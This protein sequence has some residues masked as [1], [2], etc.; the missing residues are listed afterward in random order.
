M[1][2]QT[3]LRFGLGVRFGLRCVYEVGFSF[4]FQFWKA[5]EEQRPEGRHFNGPT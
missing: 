4:E 1:K 2:I 5:N 3:E